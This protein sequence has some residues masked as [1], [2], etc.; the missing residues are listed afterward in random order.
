M[1]QYIIYDS[2]GE[3]VSIGTCQEHLL[4]KIPLGEGE[5]IME[6]SAHPETQHIAIVAGKPTI[7]RKPPGETY[8]L[9]PSWVCE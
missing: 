7:C 5:R 9:P 8:T 4:D 6:G 2:V 1:K 3:I